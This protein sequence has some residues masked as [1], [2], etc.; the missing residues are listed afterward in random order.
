[1]KKNRLKI[2][3]ILIIVII[4][5]IF[6][7]SGCISSN[8]SENTSTETT[9]ETSEEIIVVTDKWIKRTNDK[10]L[11]MIGTENE[12]FKIEDNILIGK[13][14]SSDIYNKIEIGKQ[15]K[16]Q[17]TGMRS[18]FMSWYRNI[19]EIELYEVE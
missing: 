10:D 6:I 4:A 17:T 7:L 18:N 14:N 16:I 5:M 11:Y 9:N 1:M 12:V 15:Y 19:N 2:L 13:F 3:T 8:I